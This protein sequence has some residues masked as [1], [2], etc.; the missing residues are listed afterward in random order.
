MADPFSNQGSIGSS[1]NPF[2]ET[3]LGSYEPVPILP[4]SPHTISLLNETLGPYGA[5][6]LG[7]VGGVLD[8]PGRASRSAVAG[9]LN[10]DAFSAAELLNIL[11]LP[12]DYLGWTDPNEA[13]YGKDLTGS[14]NILANI[15]T[16]IVLDPLSWV[17]RVTPKKALTP[18]GQILE[19]MGVRDQ[20]LDFSAKQKG[21]R[22]TQVPGTVGYMSSSGPSPQLTSMDTTVGEG[23]ELLRKHIDNTVDDKNHAA[24]LKHMLNNEFEVLAKQSK[25]RGA[26]DEL[27]DQPIGTLGSVTT[28]LPFSVGPVP[29]MLS[30]GINFG[31]GDW[32]KAIASYIDKTGELWK[33][34]PY[35]N[36]MRRWLSK[37]TGGYTSRYSQDQIGKPWDLKSKQI[38]ARVEDQMY[39]PQKIFDESRI[40]EGSENWVT[41]NQNMVERLLEFHEK[42]VGVT[43]QGTKVTYDVPITDP[44]AVAAFEKTLNPHERKIFNRMAQR[45]VLNQIQEMVTLKDGIPEKMRAL[46]INAQDLS[47]EYINY[48]PRDIN[49]KYMSQKAVDAGDLSSQLGRKE[50]LRDLP[51]GTAA[52]NS[53]AMDPQ[54]SGFLKTNSLDALTA[55]DRAALRSYV[56]ERHPGVIKTHT[57]TVPNTESGRYQF[58]ATN[59]AGKPIQSEPGQVW[60]QNI[61]RY[62]GKPAYQNQQGQ[63]IGAA[64]PPGW[65]PPRYYKDVSELTD[66]QIGYLDDTIDMMVK[67][68]P[69]YAEKGTRQSGGFVGGTPIFKTD[70]VSTL[71][72]Y[73]TAN[74]RRMQ[75]AELTFDTVADSAGSL[76]F[77]RNQGVDRQDLIS[78]SDLL[79]RDAFNMTRPGGTKGLDTLNEGV[80]DSLSKRLNSPM[81][82]WADE[83]MAGVDLSKPSSLDNLYIVNKSTALKGNQSTA[84]DL[85]RFMGLQ[86][87]TGSE[88]E[89]FVKTIASKLTLLEP[90][91]NAWRRAITQPHISYHERNLIGGQSNNYVAGM[92]SINSVDIASHL[93]VGNVPKGLGSKVRF[94]PQKLP[95]EMAGLVDAEGYLKVGALGNEAMADKWAAQAILHE[96]NAQ[97]VWSD[98]TIH[99][100]HGEGW[101]SGGIPRVKE[102]E[103]IP[104]LRRN[105]G[106]GSH[107]PTYPRQSRTG[108]VRNELEDIMRRDQHGTKGATAADLILGEVTG[109]FGGL[110][111]TFGRGGVGG[112][113]GTHGVLGIPKTLKTAVTDQATFRTAP[114][115]EFSK[116]YSLGNKI[117]NDIEFMNR[118]APYVELRMQGFS[119]EVAAKRVGAAQ[120]DYSGMSEFESK[121]VRQFVPFWGFTRSMIPFVAENSLLKPASPMRQMISAQT[122]TMAQSDWRHLNERQRQEWGATIPLDAGLTA[123]QRL[124]LNIGGSLPH[125]DV[126]G[127]WESKFSPQFR[128]G[129]NA[130]LRGLGQEGTNINV[131]TGGY[132]TGLLP[133][134]YI[135]TEYSKMVSKIP[136]GESYLGIKPFIPGGARQ[137]PFS[138]AWDAL[139]T[140]PTTPGEDPAKYE[141]QGWHK[142]FDKKTLPGAAVRIFSPITL[143]RQDKRVVAQYRAEQD[144]LH[145][146]LQDLPI[147][148]GSQDKRRLRMTGDWEQLSPEKRQEAMRMYDEWKK[149]ENLFKGGIDPRTGVPQ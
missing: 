83:A 52:L 147:F 22:H 103:Y 136:G 13:V 69:R 51:G 1:N 75:A 66:A 9:L 149:L 133:D 94:N 33:S 29:G 59:W 48:F 81:N 32:S 112:P 34:A 44:S 126:L 28:P 105:W 87:G 123:N 130:L 85:E 78:V 119:P 21:R 61:A 101:I 7:Y 97:R 3:G 95:K 8:K 74:T 143:G 15:G 93:R 115:T 40:F 14:D 121:I 10:K 122:R 6:A 148:E 128:V 4:N 37:P 117:G 110:G 63:W 142:L 131:N 30:P 43:P 56:V 60:K 104:E 25:Y 55:K 92:F 46:G 139:F 47:D 80:W 67:L 65:S 138:M 64:A 108:Y 91:M 17:G 79:K 62:A 99:A 58:P 114:D 134:P 111:A 100:G 42:R 124:Y 50:H 84:A 137:S 49:P 102:G 19:K 72:N 127:S 35:V 2:S 140:T 24:M 90:Y 27:L 45:G 125:M 146:Y 132:Q 5:N 73:L 145:D 18:G 109:T 23:L 57:S 36:Q 71:K 86:N 31:K 11:P 16:E 77:W 113:T 144:Q 82:F 26:A 89:G 116:I 38:N 106:P 129:A 88:L 118:V 53:L 98:Q 76:D 135:G 70:K 107:D 12:T 120:G 141:A 68:D 41:S 54:V 96:I 39:G 20:I